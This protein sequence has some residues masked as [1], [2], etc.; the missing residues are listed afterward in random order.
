MNL[1]SATALI[2]LDMPWNPAALDQRIARIHRLGQKQKVQIFLL[3][4][5]DFY[6]QRVASLVK[7]KRHLFD[8]VISPDATEE[9]V[10][11]PKKIL[12]TLIDDLAQAE[13]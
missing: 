8:N 2:N 4:A 11:V 9:V 3:L 13:P 12:Q 10:G 7:G 6:E 5:E 1:Q